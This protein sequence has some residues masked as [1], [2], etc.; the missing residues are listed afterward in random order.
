MSDERLC[1]DCQRPF[2]PT[3]RLN[4][5]C[6]ECRQFR[7]IV[8]R[9]VA[10]DGKSYVGAVGDGRNRNKYGIRR[11]NAR[12]LEAFKQYP[13]ETWTFE[14]LEWLP[15]GHSFQDYR[16][17]DEAEQRHIDRLRSWDPAFGFNMQPV[18]FQGP[19]RKAALRLYREA[20]LA[21]HQAKIPQQR[22]IP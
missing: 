14:V 22:L 8:Y 11:S 17:K 5:Y 7:P 1:H 15:L 3:N 12:L 20:H 19:A 13:P 6:C 16:N 9:Y 18:A 2:N 10:P 21:W 4:K